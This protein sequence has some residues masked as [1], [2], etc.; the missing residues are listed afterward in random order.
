MRGGFDGDSQPDLR[1]DFAV[2]RGA[3]LQPRI[4][5]SAGPLESMTTG[6]FLLAN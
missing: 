4:R 6:S 2:V 1:R 5:A 3:S